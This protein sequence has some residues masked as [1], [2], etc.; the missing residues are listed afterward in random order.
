MTRLFPGGAVVGND[1]R[2]EFTR[3]SSGGGRLFE[4]DAILG[5]VPEPS[6]SLLGLLGGAMLL[7]RRR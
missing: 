7:R 6:Q 5:V 2:L 3:T 4:I 1:F